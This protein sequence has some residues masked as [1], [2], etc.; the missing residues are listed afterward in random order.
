VFEI[1]VNL[2]EDVIAQAINTACIVAFRPPNYPSDQGGAGYEAV[3]AQ[4]IAHIRKIDVRDLVVAEVEK[5][6]GP[7][8]REVVRAELEKIAKA[9][10]K[11]LRLS[12]K[13]DGE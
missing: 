12:G 3:K 6:M 1:T 2:N 4:V 9:E 10:A 13:L 8:L 5:Q 7:V 11:A